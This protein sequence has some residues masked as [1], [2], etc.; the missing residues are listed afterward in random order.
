MSTKVCF[1]YQQWYRSRKIFLHTWKEKHNSGLVHHPSFFRVDMESLWNSK[2]IIF[3][4]SVYAENCW[5]PNE[6]KEWTTV[7]SQA[8]LTFVAVS[9]FK[10]LSTLTAVTIISSYFAGSA[11]LTRVVCA[12]INCDIKPWICQPSVSN[13]ETSIFGKLHTCSFINSK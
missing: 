11:I 1:H 5:R 12:W 7:I 3:M 13:T 4:F 8:L 6:G 10:S 2:Y 9:S